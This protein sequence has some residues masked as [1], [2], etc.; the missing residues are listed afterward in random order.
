MTSPN[1]SELSP[2]D[3]RRAAAYPRMLTA[4][5]V[6]GAAMAGLL[7]TACLIAATSVQVWTYVLIVAITLTWI[8][9]ALL[10]R[11]AFRALESELGTNPRSAAVIASAQDLF[12]HRRSEG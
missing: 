12:R 7:M 1:P 4:A 6:Y 3:V 2:E 11:S 10:A 5:R 8:A 9:G